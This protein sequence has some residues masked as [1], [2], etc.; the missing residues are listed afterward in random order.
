MLRGASGLPLL[1]ETLSFVRDPLR[2]VDDHVAT[3]G[4]MFVSNVLGKSTVFACSY[5]S[6]H[7][8][9]ADTAALNAGAAYAE[10]LSA[11]YPTPNV[12]L[13]DTHSDARARLANMFGAALSEEKSNMYRPLLSRLVQQQIV[14]LQAAAKDGVVTIQ[15]YTTFKPICERLVV[16]LVL[17]D[18]LDDAT[19]TEVRQLASLHFAGVVAAPLSVRALGRRSARARALDSRKRLLNIISTTI[20]N[21]RVRP[22][23]SVLDSLL[24]TAQDDE[25]LGEHLLLL[26]SPVISKCIASVLSSLLLELSTSPCADIDIRAALV[27]TLRMYPPL[28]GG[29]RS[30]RTSATIAHVKVPS[31][32]RVWWSARHANRDETIYDQP[33]DFHPKRWQLPSGCPFAKLSTIQTPQLPLTF[34]TGSLLC[35]GRYVAWIAMEELATAVLQNFDVIQH[36]Q[37]PPA[38]MRYIPVC[39]TVDDI[40]VQLQSKGK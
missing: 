9:L 18:R 31:R 16:A 17:G 33:N 30:A 27:E 24:S 28:L 39:R 38:E 34:G 14:S 8:V 1:G 25:L 6:A 10:F 3:Y 20:D 32:H 15:L 5:K 21:A 23:T 11:L 2:F 35:P 40:V 29:M 37:R 4:D 26:I 7:D 19:L 36:Y 12:L 13:A 22:S